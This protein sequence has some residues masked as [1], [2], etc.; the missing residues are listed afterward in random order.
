MVIMVV[1][2]MMTG[3]RMMMSPVGTGTA[4]SRK[5]THRRRGDQKT[6]QKSV[7]GSTPFMLM[8]LCE[9]GAGLYA[10]SVHDAMLF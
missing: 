8:L 4:R 6:R 7:H 1:M 9:N 5:R 2:T 3:R 10:I